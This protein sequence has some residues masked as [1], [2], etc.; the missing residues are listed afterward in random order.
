[1]STPIIVILGLAVVA[2][3]MAVILSAGDSGSRVTIIK[4]DRDKVDDKDA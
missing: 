2:L 1:M 3:I 4:E